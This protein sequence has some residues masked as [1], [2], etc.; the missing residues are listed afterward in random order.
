MRYSPPDR[1]SISHCPIQH[2]GLWRFAV[3]RGGT[4]TD[5]IG[6]D[7]TGS[8]H[9]IKILSQC[10]DYA[11]A[12]IEGIRRF[13][14]SPIDQPLPAHRVAWIRLGTTV[15]TNALLE[16]SGAKVGLLITQGFRD[17]L[18][19]G[20]QRRP[21]LFA[22]AIQRPERLYHAVEEIPE[23]L[24]AHGNMLL[25]LNQKALYNSLT[26]LQQQG[27]ESLAIVF[28]HA[29]KNPAHEQKA[30]DIAK[31]FGFSQISISCET[32]SL[33]QIVNRGRTTL[34][35]AYLTP[36]LRRYAEQIQ[37]WTGNIPLH[38][39]GSSGTLLT[40]AM[41]TG[42]DATLSGPVGGVFGC[43]NVAKLV[44][45]PQVIG[46]DMGG[47]ST[48]V[49]RFD[50]QFERVLQVETAGI[51][52]YADMLRV[53]TVAAGG[54]SIL[55]CQGG[56]LAVGPDSAGANPGPA[57]YGLGG[58]ATLTDAN[59]I[60]GRIVPAMF[61]QLFG[62]Q[63][64]GPL[65]IGA[66][67]QRM[68][69]MVQQVK[70]QTQQTITMEALA[71]G[72][73]RIAIETMGRPIK[74]LS[75][76]RGYDLRQHGLISFGGAGGQ[77][78][79]GIA[80]ALG[81]N[82]IHLHPFMSLLSAFGI[83]NAAHRHNRVTTLLVVLTAEILPSLSR[84]ARKMAEDLQK[85]MAEG[86]PEAL[87]GT[88]T[89]HI[90]VDL[91]TQGTDSVL[92]LDFDA[93]LES[94][95]QNFVLQHERH[96]GFSPEAAPIELVNLYV[97]VVFAANNCADIAP[98]DAP[99]KN[100]GPLQAFGHQQVWFSPEKPTD[101]VP[102]YQGDD[103]PINSPILGPALITSNHSVVVLEPG[104]EA[105]LAKNGILTLF[106]RKKAVEAVHQAYDPI[107]LE[108]FNH[109]FMGIATQ[110]G[111]TLAR[112]AHSVNIKERLDFS[113]ALFDAQGRL[114]VNA[115]H[116]PVHLGAMS[117][118]VVS[119]IKCLDKDLLPGDVY[120]CNDPQQGGSHLSDVTAIAP[121]FRKQKL[122]FFVASRG[123][124][125]DIGGLLP[126]SMSP[127]AKHI[128]EE[129]VLFS[130]F[131]VVQ[132][133]QFLKK[134]VMAK[135]TTGPYPARNIP[136]RLSDLRAQIAACQRGT[137]ALLE[138]CHINGDAVVKSYM[139]H[140]RHNAACAMEEA[141]RLLL[142]EQ[143]VW[144]GE[145]EDSLDSGER[146]KVAIKIYLD[147][148][149]R[150]KATIDFSGTSAPHPD[151]LNAPPA[152]T[153]AA[154]LY[155]FR[156][157]INRPIP[158]NDGCLIPIKIHIPRNSLLDPGPGKAVAGGNVE[159]A[160]RLVDVLYGA[161][162]VAAASQGTMNNFLF[163][164]ADGSG[165]QY[166]ETIA[167]GSG[168]ILG[169]HGAS[170]VQVHMTN[171]RITDPEILE[172]RFEHVRLERFE[173]R[174][175][176]GGL[177]LWH[178]GEGVVRVFHFLSPMM[179]TILSQRRDKAPFGLCG[180]SPG[181]TG[182]NWLRCHDQAPEKLP[183]RYQGIVQ[184]GDRVE[185]HTPGGGGFGKIMKT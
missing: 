76:A 154:V 73:V 106:L 64:R 164:A 131:L 62:P 130:H 25:E 127:F 144:Q 181:A 145:F 51:R 107:L 125:A 166:Y 139:K 81:I 88:V 4:F 60:L 87:A 57:C 48:D 96:Y 103:L 98:Q 163:G 27:I 8:Y 149:A 12:A 11:D 7:P 180:G 117:D 109:R 115:P 6:I 178:G 134:S 179:I 58:P 36:I 158:L 97:E 93:N 43:A 68:Q 83:A 118:T 24:D 174:T 112:T 18:E 137:Q 94:L 170:G 38:F 15:A 95:K 99:L 89:Q 82:R 34:V 63:R 157:L 23:R 92:H 10:Q 37:H 140:M 168:A 30:R 114:I 49:C 176:S 110:M 184:S 45:E 143:A 85:K 171:T 183:G 16:R 101:Q 133:G 42:K 55:H 54:G 67:R 70:Q 53:E 17:L 161:L 126:G 19:I 90:S 151:N 20:G 136:E 119:L 71:L 116:V 120:L 169:A 14:N 33:I 78:A 121:V 77:H 132:N 155:V 13:L 91:R 108:L 160:Q 153:R 22:L 111:E 113:C 146:I 129:G 167:G 9:T 141:L 50:G 122:A 44:A 72:F 65:D 152:I 35:D 84:Q 175:G 74:D 2:R 105:V 147:A 142:K 56:K 104:F 59:V 162:G 102:V 185:I 46:F 32:L 135:L 156:T 66:A 21:D 29:W 41:F 39:M 69:E 1:D 124:H 26:K 80:Q 61:P 31:V 150:P 86:L 40:P 52:Y 177:G 148:S 28:M 128:E 159:T 79:C 165:S 123:H 100:H 173:L 138:L 5:V 47:T 182:E 3:D 75:I 172:H